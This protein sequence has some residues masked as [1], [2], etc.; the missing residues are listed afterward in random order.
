MKRGLC[1]NIG[2]GQTGEELWAAGEALFYF[3]EDSGGKHNRE[4]TIFGPQVL[5]G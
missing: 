5:M 4:N 3:R 2:E 1:S